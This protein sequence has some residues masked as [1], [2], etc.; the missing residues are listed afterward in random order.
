[1]TG[2]DE[3]FEG[4]DEY[5]HEAKLAFAADEEEHTLRLAVHSYGSPQPIILSGREAKRLAR[6]LLGAR[7]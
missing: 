4:Q 7:L 2:E 3:F 1:M 5:G 6:R